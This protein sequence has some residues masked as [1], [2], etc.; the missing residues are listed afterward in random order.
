MVDPI[1]WF[2]RSKRAVQDG[3]AVIRPA[4]MGIK[5]EVAFSGLRDQIIITWMVVS[6][7][8]RTWPYNVT[9]A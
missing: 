3:Q 5:E 1:A 4:A 2:N 9:S 8:A 7:T 6:E